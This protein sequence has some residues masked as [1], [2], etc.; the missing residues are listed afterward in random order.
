M[1]YYA[2]LLLAACNP[3]GTDP[4][5]IV[6]ADDVDPVAP[7]QELP[8]PEVDA[9]DA[10]FPRML[11]VDPDPRLTPYVVVSS[12]RYAGR[13]GLRIETATGGIPIIVKDEVMYKGQLVDAVASYDELCV[14]DECAPT[15]TRIYVSAA[16][17]DVKQW[18]LQQTID[19]ELAHIISGWG[20]A[21][22]MPMHFKEPGHLLSLGC[23]NHVCAPW[24]DEDATMMCAGAP[25]TKIDLP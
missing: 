10:L 11:V 3:A 18:A 8:A 16:L 6:C 22:H 17:L 21:A 24:T 2:L 7:R 25:C 4:D 5:V 19:H 15:A 23:V 12:D 14:F 20:S 13:V 9:P 1:K